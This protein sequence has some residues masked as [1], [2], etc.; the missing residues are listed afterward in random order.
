MASKS[1]LTVFLIFLVP[2]PAF[3]ELEI[4][5]AFYRSDIPFPQFLPFWR[6][7]WDLKDLTGE[8]LQYAYKGMP[9]GGSIH[10]FVRNAEEKPLE[11]KDVTLEGT[12]LKR[13][14]VFSE[15]RLKRYLHPASIYFADLS[16]DE[17]DRLISVGEPIWWRVNPQ[18]VPPNGTTEIVVR[19]R[20]TP[21]SEKV[22]IKLKH[23][24][25]TTE[26]SVPVQ[27]EHPRV[28]DI[29]FSP[30]LDRI[31][32]YFRYPE[33]AGRK[34]VRVLMDGRDV[35]D[36]SSIGYDETLEIAPVLIHLETPVSPGSFHC[37]Q[38]V[39]ADGAVASAGIRVWSD[40]FAY[41][42]WGAKPG[43]ASDRELARWYLEDIYRHNINVQMEMIGSEAV[44]KF[45][46]SEDGRRLCATLGIRRMVN[47]PGKGNT[48]NP[49]AYFLVDEPDC[50][51]YRVAGLKP[52]QR[53]GSLAQA[54]VQRSHRLRLKDPVTPHL[55]NVDLTY[56]PDNWY[57]YGQ[58]PDIF[59]SDPYYQERLRDAY[60]NHPGRLPLY[61][62]AIYVYA[63]GAISRSA[64]APKPLHLILNSVCHTEKDRRFRYATP[65][66]KRIEVYYA[67]AAGAKGISY[68]WYTPVGRYVGVGAS[69]PEAAALWREIG[70]L[71]AE[72]RTAGPVIVRSCPVTLPITASRRLWVRSLLAGLD[73]LAIICV[74]DDYASDRIGTVVRPLENARVNLK[75]PSWLDPKDVFEI[76]FEGIRDITWERNGSELI[77]HLGMVELTRLILITADAQLRRRLEDLYSR[78]APNVSRLVNHETRAT[79]EKR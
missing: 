70:L 35:T 76:T 55:L 22:R 40:E 63:V 31:Y 69:D 64:C 77:L 27:K 38:A 6:E 58:L 71:G 62:K 34:I 4:L 79:G 10:I 73:T 2:I 30:D 39:Y 37:F 54:L 42:I 17:R 72:V 47:D 75:L 19:L 18:P 57:I 45:L 48:K 61:T 44:R 66:E 13:A 24:D 9:L 51:D 49:Y 29:S 7:S 41:G 32:L 65:E 5:G 43:R 67:I 20:R 68:W 8:T 60:W 15:Q 46:K 1:L 50:G 52:H 23:A 3:S 33:G 28:E 25:G 78:F 74:N 12:S 26:I 53:V 21:Q 16:V 11:I 56:K 59:A 14:I 36:S